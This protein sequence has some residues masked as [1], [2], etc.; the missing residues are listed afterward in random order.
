MKNLI[1]NFTPTGMIPTKKINP[2]VPISPSEIIEQVHEASEIGITLVHIHTRTKNGNPNYK[3]STYQKIFNGI[4]KY[5]P[6]LVICASLSGRTFK[7]FKK[8]SEVIELQP[9]MGSLTLGSVNSPKVAIMNSPQLIHKLALNMQQY[10][11]KPELEA[12]DS[13][14]INYGKYLIKKKILPKV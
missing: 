9:D 8:R 7:D 3:A 5:C 12:F 13:G 14:M 1:I 2:N 10:G 6:E 11:V 4:K